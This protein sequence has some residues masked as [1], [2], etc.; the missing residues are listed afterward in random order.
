MEMV[1][2][3]GEFIYEIDNKYQNQNIFIVSHS[4]ASRGFVFRV[5]WRNLY[6]TCKQ[7]DVTYMM[8]NAE[9]RPFLLLRFLIM[10]IM[11]LIC[12]GLILMKSRWLARAAEVWCAPKK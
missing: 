7:K 4:G 10:K 9:I 1:R 12:T 3:V 2:R 5:Q 6:G 8:A 11:N